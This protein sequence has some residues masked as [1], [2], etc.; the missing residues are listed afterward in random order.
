MQTPTAGVEQITDVA[1]LDDGLKE[2]M[3]DVYY[4]EGASAKLPV[5]IDIH[6]GGWMAGSKEINKNYC[7]A[8]AKRG[9]CVFN[10]NY[11]LAGEYRFHEQIEDILRRSSGYMITQAD[12]PRILTVAI[13]PAIPRAGTMPFVPRQYP[14]HIY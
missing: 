11:R 10:L 9:Y 3:L 7:L 2:H 1:Y 6:G 13:L 12:S 5:I 8:I 4:P 14:A